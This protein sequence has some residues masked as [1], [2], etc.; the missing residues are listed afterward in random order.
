MADGVGFEPTV[1]SP[2]RRFSRPVPSTARPPIRQ[3]S[4]KADSGPAQAGVVSLPRSRAGLPVDAGAWFAQSVTCG[5][6]RRRLVIIRERG[7]SYGGRWFNRGGNVASGV[8]QRVRSDAGPPAHQAVFAWQSLFGLNALS[9]G[10]AGVA[11]RFGDV[12]TRSRPVVK[13]VSAA[14][15]RRPSQAPKRPADRARGGQRFAR[16][17]Q[18]LVSSSLHGGAGA[19]SVVRGS[20]GCVLSDGRGAAWALPLRDGSDTG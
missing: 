4:I 12:A 17:V 18:S 10:A 3:R 6:A 20:S 2:A 13:G 8:G 19:G 15:G 16:R 14:R 7:I 5:G 11:P 9:P 1:R